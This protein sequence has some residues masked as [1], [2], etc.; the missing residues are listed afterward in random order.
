MRPL[1]RRPRIRARPG[2]RRRLGPDGA[3][4]EGGHHGVVQGRRLDGL[5]ELGGDDR[6]APVARPDRGHDHDG[7]RGRRVLVD[8]RVGQR[9]AVHLG[10]VEVEDR[11]V[12]RRAVVD[13]RQR[14]GGRARRPRPH[15]P[16]LELRGEDAQVGG[17]VVHDEDRA[18]G[19]VDGVGLGRRRRQVGLVDVDRE[20]E[21]AALARDAA[22]LR[23]QRAVHELG[24]APADREPESRPAVAPG[25]RH[26]DLAE[27][28]EQ[29]AHGLGRDADAGVADGDRDLPAARR[30]TPAALD[31]MPAEAQLHLAGGGEL[32]RV[33][34]EVDDDLADA[35]GI[36]EDARRQLVVHRVD[37]LD[38]VVGRRRGEQVERPLDRAPEVHRLGVQLDLAGL[39]LGE[40]EDVVDDRQQRV[41][42][43][44]D[45]LR[46]LLLLGVQRRVEQQPA[47]P[48]DRVH[49]RPDL[50]AHRRQERALGLVRVLG[51]APRLERLG[52]E[53]GVLDR[54][55]RLLGEALE[56]REVGVGE[57]AARRRPPDG[58]HADDLVASD[59]RDGHQ[60]LFDI[61]RRPGDDLG[62]RIGHHVVHD[63]GPAPCGRVADDPLAHQDRVGEDLVRSLAKC[64]DGPERPAV[65]VR[66]VD[67]AGVDLEQRLCPLGH[68]L[69]HHPWLERGRD[70]S[71]DVDQRGHLVEPPAG[72][73]EQLGVLDG[74]ADGRGDR[75]EQPG[76][77]RAEP[78]LLLHAL[79]ADHADRAV[80]E[81][82]RDAQVRL[83]GRAD[84][85][86]AVGLEVL[87]TVQ[88]QRFAA[89]Q[90]ARGQALAVLEARLLPTDAALGVVR[91]LDPVR[92]GVVHRDVHQVGREG[93]AHQVADEV[94]HPVEVELGGH[95]LA[96]LVDGRQLRHALAGLVD[97]AGVL[98][99][100]AQAG[101]Q[102]GQ[103]ADV[104]VGERVLAVEVLERDDAGR[105]AADEQG[106]PRRRL[107]RLALDR[108]RL[109]ELDRP[110]RGPLVDQQRLAGLDHVLADAHE[111]IGSSGNRTPRSIVYGKW[112]SPVSRS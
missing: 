91:E 28:P 64:H 22:A 42:R 50:V 71:R 2:D 37:Q 73:P 108:A 88:Q 107:R 14:L 98:E 105:L 78:A 21:R 41:A 77:G 90:D 67:G 99:R 68:P 48:D 106:R 85:V 89:A 93:V 65:L 33:R 95:G 19:D 103:D 70:L 86:D 111:G 9:E 82:D 12:E 51:G 8:E 84:H 75:L 30:V 16:A 72:V 15:R 56:E 20:V 92:L 54:D 17:V 96:D 44:L 60:P 40:V 102:R 38:V 45:R 4:A 109:S 25:D 59:Q 13:P 69:Q 23:G 62:T 47:H 79:D 46:V 104:G 76:V 80:A 27:R 53:P 74:D 3:A 58:R 87:P 100:D 66:E 97:Q 10:H 55:R 49:R 24:E 94:V 5:R 112:M 29:P 83:H 39:D 7:H 36:A 57:R 32:E 81:E 43:G 26:V 11:E 52:V 1:V 61:P 31:R 101:G 18:A 6:L 63:L 34:E 110:L 35:P